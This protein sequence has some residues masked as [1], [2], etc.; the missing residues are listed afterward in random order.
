MPRAHII[1]LD[2]HGEY[3]DRDVDGVVAKAP[4]PE[5]KVRSM[6]ARE[7]EFPYWLLSYG[8]LC[9]LIIDKADPN[10]TIQLSFL[11]SLMMRLKREANKH[12]DLGHITVDS[13]VYYPFEEFIERLRRR[14]VP[15]GAALLDQKAIAG[16]GNVY[17]AEIL[18][19]AGVDPA[20][21]SNELG[22]SEARSIWAL[23]VDHLRR[24]ER[25]GRIVTVDPEEVGARS[26]R[27]LKRAERLYAYK[28]DGEE[29]R[30][31]GAE[32]RIGESTG[33]S[34]WW[35]PVCQG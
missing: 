23:S 12:L 27:D 5:N 7:L 34:I 2:M 33:R 16:V 1:L 32:I 13:P 3:C 24:G 22:E 10:S 25:A 11:R 35:C 31:C 6:K 9:D 14:S 20:T 18:F 17:R 30:R 21:P 8:E 28:R 19:L 4:F 15:I 26:R 29:C